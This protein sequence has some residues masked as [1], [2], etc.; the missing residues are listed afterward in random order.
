MKTYSLLTLLT[1]IF[2]CSEIETNVEIE[3]IRIIDKPIIPPLLTEEIGDNVQGPSLIKAPTWLKNSLGKYYLY[4]ADHKGD[5]IK[6]AYSDSLIGPWTVHFGGTLNLQDSYFLKETPDIPVDFDIESLESREVHP[7]LINHIPKKIDDL[8]I[9]HIASPDAHVDDSNE[10]IIMYYHGLDEFGIQRT[11]VATSKDG[12]NFTARKKIVGWPYFRKFTYKNNN[13]A[14]SMP[15]VIYKNI[16]DIEDF[17]IV[18]Q[19][20]EENTRH[21][22]VLVK[23]DKL[24][25]FYTRKGDSPERILLTTLDLTKPSPLWKVSKPIEV[26]KPEKE[27]EGASLPLYKSVQS[28]INVP[29]NQLRDPAIY[30]ENGKNYLLY[31]IRGENGI[32]IVEFSVKKL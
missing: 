7:D 32:G 15:G 30:S 10:R 21:S 18:N 20:M 25:I 9:P 13:Y 29:V 23:G 1:L 3:I 28:A 4:F 14:L 31:S 27:W 8:T 5:R 6:L 2:G 22:A 11:R 24:L 12:I 19:V 16:G 26:L 17:T